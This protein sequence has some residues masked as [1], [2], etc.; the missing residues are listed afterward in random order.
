MY[1]QGFTTRVSLPGIGDVLEGECRPGFFT[2]VATV[3]TKLLCQALPDAA[4]FGEKD[5]QQL[6]IVRCLARDLDLP[7]EIVGCPIIREPDGLALSSRNAYLSPQERAVA[8]QLQATLQA[9]RD[10]IVGGEDSADAITRG[11]AGLIQAG[12]AGVDYIALRAAETLAPVETPAGP[13]R[14]LSAAWLGKTRLIDN[15]AVG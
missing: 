7:V 3:V 8:P 10:A 5:Y 13:A 11:E 12:F 15:I 2:G 9:V 6:C 1:P 14:L 4:F